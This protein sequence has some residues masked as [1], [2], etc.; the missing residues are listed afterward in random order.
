MLNCV[1]TTKETFFADVPNL[2]IDYAIKTLENRELWRSCRPSLRYPPLLQR[3]S[4]VSKLQFKLYERFYVRKNRPKEQK[5]YRTELSSQHT[6]TRFWFF[7]S[8]WNYTLFEQEKTHAQC[9]GCLTVEL[10]TNTVPSDQPNKI[11]K[12]MRRKFLERFAIGK[13]T[14]FSNVRNTPL[15]VC[16]TVQEC[17]AYH[18]LHKSKKNAQKT[19]NRKRNCTIAVRP[20]H[21]SFCH[22]VVQSPTGRGVFQNPEWC[23]F[24]KPSTQ[25]FNVVPRKTTVNRNVL[26]FPA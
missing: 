7:R 22:I 5:M 25:S 13:S 2:N 10:V 18:V 9:K 19:T 11:L 8:S 24:R 15:V 3:C 20:A 1:K 14:A 23:L 16:S 21:I 17:L 4:K 6:G 26:G 12:H